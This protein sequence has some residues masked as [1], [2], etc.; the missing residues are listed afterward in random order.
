MFRRIVTCFFLIGF[1]MN[2]G[3]AQKSQA[4][5]HLKNGAILKGYAKIVVESKSFDS[6]ISSDGA[7][8][9]RKSME[10]RPTF[11]RF[12]KL[13]KVRIIEKHRVATYEFFKVIGEGKIKA[14]KLLEKGDVSLYEYETK[15]ISTKSPFVTDPSTRMNPTAPRNLP[16]GGGKSKYLCVK[17]ENEEMAT[18]LTRNPT[19]SNNFKEAAIYYFRDCPALVEKLKKRKYKKGNIKEAVVYYN[20]T[21]KKPE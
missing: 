13:K 15:G 16:V 12:E 6:A 17:K 19:F 7:V 20:D 10:A 18:K 2:I 21:C 5:L 14:L 9:F 4:E 11:Y 3:F 1:A 8:K